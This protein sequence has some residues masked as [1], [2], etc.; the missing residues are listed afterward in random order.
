MADEPV[1]EPVET[2]PP[3]VEPVETER[4]PRHRRRVTTEPTPG[5]DPTPTSEPPR[6]ELTANDQRLR[7]EKPPHY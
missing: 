1:V 5:V 3:V 2:E 4:R 7:D 6:H